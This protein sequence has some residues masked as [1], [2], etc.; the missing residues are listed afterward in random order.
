[1]PHLSLT[2]HMSLPFLFTIKQVSTTSGTNY[3]WTRAGRITHRLRQVK[4]TATLQQ[5]AQNNDGHPQNS[6]EKVYQ[7]L[8]QYSL[9]L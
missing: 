4:C 1:M 3:D 6:P 9:H 5:G 7:I 8:S 2:L